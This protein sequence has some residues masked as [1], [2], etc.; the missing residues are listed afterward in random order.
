MRALTYF[1]GLFAAALG[2]VAVAT[3]PAW[4]LVNRFAHVPFHRV[5]NRIAMLGLAIGLYVVARRLGVA[6]RQAM[7]FGIPR[8]RFL[9]E[10]ARGIVLGILFMVPLA[11]LMVA[12]GLRDLSPGLTATAVAKV[13]LAGLGSGLAAAFIEESFLRGAMFS[14][15]SRESGTALAVVSTAVLYAAVHFFARYRIDDAD[16]AFGSGL[17]LLHGSLAEFTHPLQIADAFLCLAG[18]GLLLAM[19]RALTGNIAAGMGLHAGWVTVMLAVLRLTE[20]DGEAPLGALLSQH[21]A[22]VGWLTLGWTGV[23]AVPLLLW[24]RRRQAADNED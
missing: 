10:L 6:D 23:A 13:L 14:A 5:G 8:D 1:A 12:L 19:L 16:A 2:L 11:A 24:Y 4:Q 22:F 20:V 15:V 18:V 7:G 3:W 21:D 17:T 9:R